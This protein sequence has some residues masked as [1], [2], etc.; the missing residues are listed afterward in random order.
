[1]KLKDHKLFEEKP[2]SFLFILDMTQ[3]NSKK[4][5]ALYKDAIIK[6]L[7]YLKPTDRFN[8]IVINKQ[9]TTF[10]KE[11]I[12]VKSHDALQLEELFHVNFKNEGRMK[13]L[14][15][16]L[17]SVFYQSEESELH[18]HCIFFTEEPK[19][20]DEAFLKL[21]KYA[22]SKLSFYPVIYSEKPLEPLH[23]K[24]LV[25]NIGGRILSPPTK[26][27]FSRKFSSLILDIKQ[28]R[29]RNVSI[30]IESDQGLLDVSLSEKTKQLTLKKPLKIFGKLKGA[31]NLKLQVMG[32]HGDD[33]FEMKKTLPIHGAKKG[34]SLIKKELDLE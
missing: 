9:L 21:A 24:N 20:D 25:E 26:A 2:Q 30:K 5:W 23:L 19:K 12:S 15:R 29:L 3:K 10:F 18:T 11:A 22:H 31:K 4:K 8:V 27:S 14:A 6:S 16:H 17:G 32:S 7:K 28:T 33:L 34:S 13:D 1:L